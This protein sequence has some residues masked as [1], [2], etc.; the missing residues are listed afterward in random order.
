MHFNIKMHDANDNITSQSM[1]LEVSK[2][3]LY[4]EGHVAQMWKPL[5]RDLLLM[6][7]KLKEIGLIYID[8]TVCYRWR[9]N[10]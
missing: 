3:C 8:G 1:A 4:L 10:N 5:Y 6:Y 7:E 2:R 9:S